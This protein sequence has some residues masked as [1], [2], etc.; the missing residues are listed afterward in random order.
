MKLLSGGQLLTF[1]HFIKCSRSAKFNLYSFDGGFFKFFGC[2][3]NRL[4]IKRKFDF[5]VEKG[6]LEEVDFLGFWG[7]FNPK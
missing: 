2:K 6:F 5:G 7:D 3:I 4:V 1:S